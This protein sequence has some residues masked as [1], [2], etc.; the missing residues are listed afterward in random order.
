MKKNVDMPDI[1]FWFGRL[2]CLKS[3]L[4]FHKLVS[5]VGLISNI[6]YDLQHSSAP[7]TF[8]VVCTDDD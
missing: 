8:S 1:H 2:W 5:D 3:L 6:L 4:R 7:A